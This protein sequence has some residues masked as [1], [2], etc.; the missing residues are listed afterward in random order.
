MLEGEKSEQALI[1]T[2]RKGTEKEELTTTKEKKNKSVVLFAKVKYHKYH[3]DDLP[4]RII[5]EFACT[6]Y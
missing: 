2:K 6:D 5:R 3:R 4:I 1:K